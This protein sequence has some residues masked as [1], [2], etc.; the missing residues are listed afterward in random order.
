MLIK[1][2]QITHEWRDLSSGLPIRFHH[3]Q[4]W[5]A[6]GASVA[7]ENSIH[8]SLLTRPSPFPLYL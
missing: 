4:I 5:E 1:Y 3:L 2:N 6:E 7:T 8:F